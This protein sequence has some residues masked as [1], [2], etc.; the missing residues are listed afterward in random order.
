[1]N[2]QFESIDINGFRSINEAHVQLSNQ[3]IVVVKGINEY[4]D[5]ASSNGSGKSS[6]F[7]AIIF[8]LFEETS[9]GD[10]DVEN[11]I[12]KNGYRVVLNFSV[13]GVKYTIIRQLVKNK[14]SVSFFKDDIDISS[15]LRTDTNKLILST[16]GIT[17]D[18][19][20]DSIFLS[21]N[22]TTNLA[23]LSPTARRERLEI[24]T[25]TDNVIN[26]F[27]DF[28]KN[29]QHIYEAECNDIDLQKSRLIG[30]K[31]AIQDEVLE[32]QNKIDNIKNEIEKRKH[33]GTLDEIN[34]N[35]DNT[36]T[37][38]NLNF[39]NIQDIDNLI[40]D[41]DNTIT[42]INTDLLKLNSYVSEKQLSVTSQMEPI[43][44][45]NK[46]LSKCTSDKN[47]INLQI[48]KLNNEIHIIETSDTCPACG[49]KYDDDKHNT[50]DTIKKLVEVKTQEITENQNKCNE[51]DN[52]IDDINK[53]LLEHQTTLNQIYD[54]IKT[55]VP[56]EESLKQ[57]LQ[58]QTNIKQSYIDK[59]NTI[60]M[61]INKLQT[62]L[63]RLNNIKTELSKIPVNNLEEFEKSLSK[64]NNQLL[65]LES[66]IQ[67]YTKQYD[68]YCNLIGITK[69]ITQLIT[70]DFRT[71]LLK[72]S[73]QYLN[74][75]LK[76]YS[77]KLFSNEQDVIRIEDC[78]S[79]LDI[80]LGSSTYESLSGGERTRVNIALL[81]AQK[82]LASILGNTS[83]NIIILDE[84]LGYCDSIAESKVIDLILS[85]LDTLQTIYMVSHK[86]ISVPYDTELTVIKDKQGL[87]SIVIY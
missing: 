39:T 24:L 35:I 26:N 30:N 38:I 65:E 27:K 3:G 28:I 23:S 52:T 53:K 10:K 62:E 63:E 50:Q 87:S 57:K 18:V 64:Y 12:L 73:V 2:I 54:D 46:Q 22:A 31:E 25:N 70:K 6:I 66:N 33:L 8:A 51:L 84:V 80:F 4:E 13:D 83:C 58:E 1:M 44:E 82:S 72:N 16:L 77:I 37:C 45:L 19:F 69:H 32:L 5:N 34:K 61:D 85:E 29:K 43:N 59:K 41:T 78:D 75:L 76:S 81:L 15:R 71:Y 9:S 60:M 21:Q 79:K 47:Y 40:R 56:Q 36:N 14:L 17:K 11:R 48:E 86:E 42:D 74:N 68:R 49:R 67:N 7:E 55:T 20:L